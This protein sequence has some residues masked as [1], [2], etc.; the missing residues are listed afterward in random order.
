MDG[1]VNACSISWEI[2]DWLFEMGFQVDWV[3]GPW[4]IFVGSCSMPRTR[5]PFFWIDITNS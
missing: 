1:S 4:I 5:F 3:V 2:V